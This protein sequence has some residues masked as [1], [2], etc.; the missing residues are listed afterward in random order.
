MFVIK[1]GATVI[2]YF[3][4]VIGAHQGVPVSAFLFVLSLEILFLL[5][6]SKPE[7]EGMTIFDYNYLYYAYAVDTTFFFVKDNC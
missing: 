5:I 2:K 1:G 6:K 4:L 3:S 7:I